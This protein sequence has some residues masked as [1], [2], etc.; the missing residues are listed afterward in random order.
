MALPV[1]QQADPALWRAGPLSWEPGHGPTCGAAG[2]PCAL[3]GRAAELGAGSWSYLW[4]SRLTLRSG[5]QGRWAGSRVVA[6]P[7][8]LE[9]VAPID[10][11]IPAIKRE[12]KI[13]QN[14]DSFVPRAGP[15]SWDIKPGRW[16]CVYYTLY[17]IHC[18]GLSQGRGRGLLLPIVI[19]WSGY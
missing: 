6:P 10:C 2:W 17:S 4:R 8:K 15:Y 12:K 16:A 1:T 18:I 3:A 5:G 14:L 19:V 7:L 9:A 11:V 13:S